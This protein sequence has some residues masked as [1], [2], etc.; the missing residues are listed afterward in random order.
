MQTINI[1]IEGMSCGHC[2][3]AV[4]GALSEAE[5]VRVESVQMG[6]ARVTYDEKITDPAKIEAAIAE[7]GYSASAFSPR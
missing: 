4:R 6:T 1:Q 5:G 7:A 3:N 2:L